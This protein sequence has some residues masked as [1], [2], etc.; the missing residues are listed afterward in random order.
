MEMPRLSSGCIADLQKSFTI[1]ADGKGEHRNE[2]VSIQIFDNEVPEFVENM[3]ESLYENIYCT[4]ARLTVYGSLAGVH[5]YL[6]LRNSTPDCLI[7]FRIAGPNINVLNQQISLSTEQIQVFCTSAF[8]RYETSRQVNFY[9]LNTT[10]A[11]E[12]FHFVY[13][14]IPEIEEN[15]AVLP[16]S[17]EEFL[18]AMPAQSRARML[19]SIRKIKADHPSYEF[20]ILNGEEIG[21]T[22]VEDIVRLAAKRMLA[23]GC[24]P[25][26]DDGDIPALVQ[27]AQTYGSLGLIRIEGRLVAG[28]LSYR[29]GE[30]WF[31]QL[32]AHDPALN[33]YGLGNQL[34]LQVML[35]AI[36]RGAREFWMMGGGGVDKARFLTRRTM[37]NSITVY[38]SRSAAMRGWRS[39]AANDI[40]RRIF[41]FKESVRTKSTDDSFSGRSLARMLDAIR[42]LKAAGRGARQRARHGAGVCA[43]DE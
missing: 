34:Q 23:K 38:R 24:A 16:Q 28:T 40:K 26:I 5:T 4:V 8:D 31:A 25:Y 33:V 32:I 13:Q 22:P 10:V 36:D 42:A 11:A 20:V 30:R 43:K 18:Q 29:V 39:Y 1:S 3:L 2:V 17:G 14:E 27:L 35:D 41:S 6:S 19:K 7:L 15:I 37:L 12:R 9:A 21:F